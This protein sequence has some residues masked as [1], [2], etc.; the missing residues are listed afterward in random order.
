MLLLLEVQWM[1]GHTFWSIR[2]RREELL[3]FRAGIRE[4]ARETSK[5]RKYKLKYNRPR[6]P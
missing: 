6:N 5:K 1:D 4:T 2:L 3:V